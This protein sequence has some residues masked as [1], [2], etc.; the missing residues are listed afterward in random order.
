[1]TRVTIS[2]AKMPQE[3]LDPRRGEWVSVTGSAVTKKLQVY[4][5]LWSHPEHGVKVLRRR[6]RVKECV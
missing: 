2:M 3:N 4:T 5:R 6:E 1:M